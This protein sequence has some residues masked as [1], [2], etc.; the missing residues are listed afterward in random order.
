[1]KSVIKFSFIVISILCLTGCSTP[2]FAAPTATPTGT[3]TP[4]ATQTPTPTLTPPPTKTL[5]PTPTPLV[6]LGERHEIPAGGFAFRVPIGYTSQIEERQAFISD[7]EGRLVISFAGVE[8]TSSEEEIVDDYL[9]AL[10]KR[11]GGEFEK[12][13]SDPVTVNGKEG[14]AF[15]LT[16]SLFGSP[17]K[18]KTF[19]IPTG[20]DHFLYALAIVNVSEDEQAWEEHGA[21]VF[22]AV[23]DSIEFIEPPSA[24]A[25]PISTEPTYGYSKENA[26]RVGEGG[27]FLGGPARERSYLDNLRGPNG[28]PLSYERTGSLHFEDT[29]LDAYVI[30]GLGTP[31]TL[32]IDTYTFEELKAPVGFTCIGSFGLKP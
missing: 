16:G 17:L 7:L 4:I 25:C 9:D 2:L 1:L 28:E 13:P 30:H 18:G 22:E 12:R 10:A 29:I 23:V 19:V 5:S 8:S 21:K 32:Y 24:S 14:Q 26:I 31:V 11:S 15:D 3:F 20:S 6:K 27:D